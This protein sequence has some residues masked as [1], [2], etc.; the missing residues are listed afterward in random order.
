M[1]TFVFIVHS[2]YLKLDRMTL[3]IRIFESCRVSSELTTATVVFRFL[4]LSKTVSPLNRLSSSILAGLKAIV[5]WSSDTASSIKS[6]LGV[7]FF[8]KIAVA[9]S[10][11]FTGATGALVVVAVVVEAVLSSLLSSLT[12]SFLPLPFLL[13]FF[14]PLLLG[15]EVDS[16]FAMKI[17]A[18]YDN[19][20]S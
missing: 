7:F 8:C 2:T 14:F 10:D 18:M 6:V 13:F 15:A 1:K 11:A 19:D 20:G 16:F 17:N 9:R 3:V 5:D 4:P 12:A